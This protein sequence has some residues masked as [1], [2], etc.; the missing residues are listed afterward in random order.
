MF[1]RFSLPFLNV[2]SCLFTDSCNVYLPCHMTYIY[3]TIQVLVAFFMC[4]KLYYIILV[5]W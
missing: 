4:V 1:L 5:E 2:F 3:F